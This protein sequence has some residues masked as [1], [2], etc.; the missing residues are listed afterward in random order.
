MT[1]IAQLPVSRMEVPRE[2][3]IE[4]PGCI[5]AGFAEKYS[6]IG[7]S[8]CGTK[9]QQKWWGFKGQKTV[10]RLKHYYNYFPELNL[11]Y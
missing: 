5:F 10:E 2:E 11:G 9:E 8:S 4:E 3:Q 6:E 7:L 1:Y